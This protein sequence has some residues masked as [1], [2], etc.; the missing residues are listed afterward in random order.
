MNNKVNEVKKCLHLLCS[1]KI[2][3]YL[4][5]RKLFEKLNLE[6]VMPKDLSRGLYSGTRYIFGNRHWQ[7]VDATSHYIAEEDARVY[8]KDYAFML[9]KQ[10]PDIVEAYSDYYFQVPKESLEDAVR[11]IERKK[12]NLFLAKTM[13]INFFSEGLLETDTAVIDKD[14][15]DQEM[16]MEDIKLK[17]RY[18]YDNLISKHKKRIDD[19][20]R[21]K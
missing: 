18:Y 21:G 7:L 11:V 17:L 6:Q 10:I 16:L 12:K 1:G 15:P 13:H 14:D 19:L 3:L 9:E 20:G 8:M 4:E 5:G 2:G